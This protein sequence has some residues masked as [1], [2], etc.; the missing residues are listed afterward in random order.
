MAEQTNAELRDRLEA[1]KA[2]LRRRTSDIAAHTESV[3]REVA[4]RGARLREQN[5]E[6]CRE[7]EERAAREKADEP[8]QH[9][10]AAEMEA[11]RVRSLGFAEDDDVAAEPRMK[12]PRFSPAPPAAPWIDAATGT[13]QWPTAAETT[14]RQV[15]SVDDDEDFEANGWLRG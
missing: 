14:T 4:E 13:P 8:S 3:R 15:G 9:D 5:E 7:L 2:N 1:V 12:A 10:R 11:G 6:F